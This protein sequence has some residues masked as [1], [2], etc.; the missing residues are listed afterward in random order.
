[1]IPRLEYIFCRRLDISYRNAEYSRKKRKHHAS[2]CLVLLLKP[3]GMRS[4]VDQIVLMGRHF[5]G[6][7]ILSSLC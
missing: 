1:M 4:D 3:T 2:S 6:A 5:L 7:A